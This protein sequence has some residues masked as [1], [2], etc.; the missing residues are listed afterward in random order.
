[1]GT[2]QGGLQF[3]ALGDPSRRSIVALLSEAPAAVGA[4]A[5]RLPIS[6]PAVSQHLSVLKAAG[7]VRDRAEGTR[8]VYS[9]DD[10]GLG[11]IR[12]FLAAFWHDDLHRFAQ[13]VAD[14]SSQ[15]ADAVEPGG[16]S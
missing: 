11:E 4:L 16:A 7:L 12:A 2:Y 1:M 10:T 14:Q 13:H 8:R 9:L 5:E 6:R 15:A 3:D